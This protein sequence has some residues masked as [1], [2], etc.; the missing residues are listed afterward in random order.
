MWA[1]GD[2]HKFATE[3]IWGFGAELVAACG[4][5]AGQ[6]VLDVAAGSGN[7]AIRA[8]EAGA[9]VVASD[10]TPENFVAGRRE[11]RAR[12]VELDWVE[13]DAEDLPFPDGEFDVVT[14]A[15]GAIF[16][17]HHQTV[18]DELLRVCRP[19]GTIGMIAIVPVGIAVDLF[20]ITERYSRSAVVASASALQWGHE[21]HVREMFGDRLESLEL[22]R[23]RFVLDRFQDPAEFRDFFKANHPMAVALYRDLADEPARVAALDRELLEAATRAR[24]G[25]I[26]GGRGYDAEFLVIVARKRG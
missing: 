1:L 16:A 22:R 24:H 5:S 15:V 21:E 12:G 19:G 2:Y 14:S 10:L 11:A 25:K 26:D 18:A 4:I 20:E 7:V 3:S 13:A 6:R 17:P 23:E 8:A 9:Q